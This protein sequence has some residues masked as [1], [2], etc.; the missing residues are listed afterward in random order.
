M[1]VLFSGL[2]LWA[3][4]TF[5]PEHSPILSLSCS[6]ATRATCCQEKDADSCPPSSAPILSSGQL[7]YL[8]LPPALLWTRGLRGPE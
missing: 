4:R 1:H 5:L 6:D 7:G 3:A 8:L 2:G